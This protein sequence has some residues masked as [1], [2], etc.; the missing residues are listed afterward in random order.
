MP[1][2]TTTPDPASLLRRKIL[3]CGAGI[4]VLLSAGLVRLWD[5]QVV[6]HEHYKKKVFT[7]TTTK[8]AIPPT[9]GRIVFRND[10]IAAISRQAV[11]SVFVDPS[12]VENLEAASAAIAEALELPAAEVFGKLRKGHER[13]R[14]FVWIKRKISARERAEVRML[15]LKGVHVRHEADRAYPRGH[16]AGFLIGFVGTEQTGLEGV[17]AK[18]EPHLAG[19]P[20]YRYYFR[21]AFGQPIAAPDSKHEPAIPGADVVLTIDVRSQE[22]AEQEL[23][24][25]V[26]LWSA[27]SGVAMVMDVA[28]GELRAWAQWPNYDPANARRVPAAARGNQALIAPFAPGSG[29]KVPA[30][31]QAI[32]T[33][34]VTPDTKINCA[35]GHWAYRGRA[36][37]DFHGY[38]TLDVATVLV[39]SSN[40]GAIRTVLRMGDVERARQRGLKAGLAAEHQAWTKLMLGM[41]A[42]GFGA[43]TGIELPGEHPGKLPAK[44][45]WRKH[46]HYSLTSVPMGYEVLVTPPQLLAAFNAIANDGVWVAPHV[47]RRLEQADGTVVPLPPRPASRRVWSAEHCAVMRA[48]LAR[49]VSEGTARRAKV[50]DLAVAGKTST[51][52]KLIKGQFVDNQSRCLFTGFAPA[53]KPALSVVVMIDQ[54]LHGSRLEQTGG[55]V[56]APCANRILARLLGATPPER[57]APKLVRGESRPRSGG[58]TARGTRAVTDGERTTARPAGRRSQTPPDSELP[59]IQLSSRMARLVDEQRRGK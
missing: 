4:G 42:A 27:K 1:D 26:K 39:K 31:M 12:R 30:V 38:G 34:A 2:F 13:G 19:T 3:A 51:V 44:Q 6:R 46:D 59:P 14:R 32:A 49:V 29:M 24:E 53:D 28:T 21:D 16:L 56:S 17:E 15:G 57:I 23:A 41:R 18:F 48:I 54:P 40:I 8:L 11:P 36:I 37:K 10:E 22:V 33:G 25:T 20:G 47:V 55:R 9:R 35:G 7:Q 45:G 52:K 58:E 50:A 5:I 43:K